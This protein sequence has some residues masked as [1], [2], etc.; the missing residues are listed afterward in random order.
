M[1]EHSFTHVLDTNLTG[2]YR[3]VKAVAGPMLRTRWGRIVFVSSVV[4]LSGS[5]GQANYA[6]SKAGL[7]GL[8]RSLAREFGPRGVTCNVI[9]PGFIDTDM[10][11]ALGDERRSAVIDSIPLDRIGT[12]DDIAATIDFLTSDAGGYITGAVIPV[13]GGLGMGY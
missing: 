3:L 9:A 10:T 5:A 7:I 12:V 11:A 8:A 4:A 6:A 2:T 1:D 13:D